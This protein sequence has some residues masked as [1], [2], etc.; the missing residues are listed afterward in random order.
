MVIT[1]EEAKKIKKHLLG[2]LENFP[3]ERRTAIKNQYESGEYSPYS[4]FFC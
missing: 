3:E 4:G 1:E 2:Q